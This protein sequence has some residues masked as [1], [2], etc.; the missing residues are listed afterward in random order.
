MQGPLKIRPNLILGFFDLGSEKRDPNY[1]SGK[2]WIFGLKPFLII[3]K[4]S[5]Q[6]QSNEGPK[7]VISPLEVGH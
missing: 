4:S 5:H 6:G 7:F 3:L 2:G 1:I